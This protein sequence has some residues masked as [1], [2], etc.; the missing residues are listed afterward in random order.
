MGSK[1]VTISPKR[2]SV[3]LIIFPEILLSRDDCD[4]TGVD[5]DSDEKDIDDDGRDLN[6]NDGGVNRGDCSGNE[7][8]VSR[9][10]ID[11]LLLHSQSALGDTAT[12]SLLQ[13]FLASHLYFLDVLEDASL[14]L[15]VA[16]DDPLRR[17]LTI[18]L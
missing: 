17:C 14:D 7:E 1:P 2:I 11:C 4:D 13:L 10:L 5:D 6:E 8:N 3:F 9:N 12:L 15:L 16:I 18:N